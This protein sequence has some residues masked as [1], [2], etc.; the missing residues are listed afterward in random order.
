MLLAKRILRDPNLSQ[1]ATRKF[2]QTISQDDANKFICADAVITDILEQKGAEDDMFECE[3]K[4]KNT[5]MML[6]GTKL[7]YNKDVPSTELGPANQYKKLNYNQM[8]P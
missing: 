4:D 5:K 1:L 2:K 6:E 7:K 3:F 8:T